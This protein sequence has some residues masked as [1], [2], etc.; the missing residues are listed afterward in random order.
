MNW[1]LVQGNLKQFKGRMRVGWSSLIGDH[2]GVISG[3]RMQYTGER[4][5]A[6]GALHTRTLRGAKDAHSA[7]RFFS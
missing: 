2:L 5:S 1:D 4:Q 3:K 6:Y 7:G